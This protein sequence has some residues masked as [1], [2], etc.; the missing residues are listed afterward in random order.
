MLGS[1]VFNVWQRHWMTSFAVVK[2]F[3]L[4]LG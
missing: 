2:L 3:Q 4:S 1:S